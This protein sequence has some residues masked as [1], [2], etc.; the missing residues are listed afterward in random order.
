MLKAG[1][2][3]VNDI[4][5]LRDEKMAGVVAKYGAGVVMMHMRGTPDTMQLDP[6]YKDVVAEV[7]DF[8]A[9]RIEVARAAGISD[10]QMILDPGV[11]F[12]KNMEHNLTLLRS[13]PGLCC[14]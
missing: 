14:R 11:G 6:G 5:G 4:T 3:I 9:E 13:M 2:H 1:A 7:A 8:F 12:G 10:E